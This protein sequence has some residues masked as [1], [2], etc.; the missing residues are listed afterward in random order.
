MANPV[1]FCPGRGHGVNSSQPGARAPL[2]CGLHLLATWKT[3]G[4]WATLL[5]FGVLL[6]GHAIYWP[7]I[8][9]LWAT[10]IP[11]DFFP[12]LARFR[13]PEATPLWDP[14]SIGKTA[15]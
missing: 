8:M 7:G 3:V 5:S 15:C 13:P 9:R 12:Y 1:R 4:V 14:Q 11:T 10:W 2:L 6:I